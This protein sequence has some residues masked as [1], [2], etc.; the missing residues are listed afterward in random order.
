MAKVYG[1][2]LV[3]LFALVIMAGAMIGDNL[4]RNAGAVLQNWS[5]TQETTATKTP[6]P[7]TTI[8]SFG[9]E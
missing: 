3:V 2:V 1:L 6:P 8:I 5:N 9:K 4:G 7:L